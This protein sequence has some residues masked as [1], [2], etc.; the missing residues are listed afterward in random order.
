MRGR[1]HFQYNPLDFEKD[2]AIGLILPLSN[3][4]QAISKYEVASTAAGVGTGSLVDSQGLHEKTTA[5][6]G[7][8][9]LSYTTKEQ[10]KS[11]IR[12]LVLTNKGERVMHPEFG[13]DIY[14]SLFEPIT[15]S[16]ING[17]K[18]SIKQQCSFWLSY[19]NLLDV[20]I[21]QVTPDV[22]RVNIEIWYALYSDIINKEMVTINNIGAL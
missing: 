4:S 3:D 6:N 19:I 8:F 20:N 11:N 1:D 2:V 15:P 22:N 13:C 18:K 12:N 14:R 16:L 10:A 7:G 21:K 9:A 17:M 5:V